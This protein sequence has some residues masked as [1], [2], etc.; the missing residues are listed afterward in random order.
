MTS[1]EVTGKHVGNLCSD[2]SDMEFKR[3]LASY[4]I[5]QRNEKKLPQKIVGQPY[6]IAAYDSGESL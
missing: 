4:W 3:A 2:P 6:L 1:P 5:P